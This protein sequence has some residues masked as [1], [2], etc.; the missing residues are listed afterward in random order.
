[1]KTFKPEFTLEEL[2]LILEC[3][4]EAYITA[5]DFGVSQPFEDLYMKLTRIYNEAKR[6]SNS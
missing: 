1:M 5:E 6:D 2:R 4:D 3:V